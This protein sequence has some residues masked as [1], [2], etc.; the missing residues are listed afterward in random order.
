MIVAGL[1]AYLASV[2]AVASLLGKPTQQQGGGSAIYPT[3]AP[4]TAPAPYLVIHRI[5]TPPAGQTMDGASALKDGE[6]QFDSYANDALT[7]QKLSRTV[8]NTLENYGG[9]LPDGSTI[10]F[11]EV[12]ADMD[13]GFEQGGTGYLFRSILRLAAF[14]TEGS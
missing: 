14:Y 2:S 5:N 13:A 8:C 4:E 3:A 9:G 11:V 6:L 12:T 10:Q 7:A 1:T